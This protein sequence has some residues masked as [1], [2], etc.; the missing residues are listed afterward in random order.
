MALKAEGYPPIY[1]V[2]QGYQTPEGQPVG[3]DVRKGKVLSNTPLQK[4]PSESD[5]G[6]VRKK[7]SIDAII[8][9]IDKAMTV[10]DK[11]LPKTPSERI[12]QYPIRPV[13]VW[14][15]SSHN[16]AYAES[17]SKGFLAK[18]ARAAGDVGTLNE[19]DIKRANELRITIH[20]TKTVR[21]MKKEKWIK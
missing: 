7:V 12:T 15:Q 20:D 14:T 5:I 3:Y 4:T 6:E 19:G 2:I 17:V 18:F 8:D 16:L 21:E 10:A 9:E 1:N 13:K 11:E